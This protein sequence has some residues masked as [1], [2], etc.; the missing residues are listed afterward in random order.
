MALT[1]F[2]DPFS[3]FEGDMWIECFW[4]NSL[5]DTSDLYDSEW[6][7]KVND[8]PPGFVIFDNWFIFIFIGLIA[9][10]KY[11]GVNSNDS[12]DS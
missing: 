1:E 10:S 8:I 12:W 9:K 2:R 11:F 3:E 5:T 4:F 6:L 7:Y